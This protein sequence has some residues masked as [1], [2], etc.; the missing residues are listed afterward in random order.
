MTVRNDDLRQDRD[1]LL[2]NLM[3]LLAGDDRVRA[4]WLSGS[5]GRGTE[6]D[7]SDLDVHVAGADDAF[8]T[9]L[10]ERPSLY[11]RIGDPLLV[12][13]DKPS[14][15]GS[16]PYQGVIFPGP[17]CLDF[18]VH[19]ASTAR[20]GIDCRIQ[21]DQLP[22]PEREPPLIAPA[23]RSTHITDTLGFFWAMTTIAL[24][25][26]ARGN[27]HRAVS[28]LDLLLGAYAKVWRL[29]HNPDRMEAGGAHWLHPAHDAELVAR[30]PRL[31]ETIRRGDILD[32]ISTLMREVDAITPGCIGLGAIVPTDVAAATRHLRDLIRAGM[33]T[34]STEEAGHDEPRT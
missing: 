5:F 7:W 6:D 4:A 20:P 26:V 1:R 22:L 34:S 8:E 24:K 9:W 17:V 16:G 32:A 2:S 15:A 18:N 21:F 11:R 12:R 14:N 3:T 29:V 33:D 25:Y 31:G 28:Q 10:A 27:S 19:P 30:L 13:P 23:A